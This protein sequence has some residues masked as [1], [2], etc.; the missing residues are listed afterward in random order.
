MRAAAVNFRFSHQIIGQ[1]EKKC[2]LVPGLPKLGLIA[3]VVARNS[4]RDE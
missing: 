4:E 1:A 3:A 2:R